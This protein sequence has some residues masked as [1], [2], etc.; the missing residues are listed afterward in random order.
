[1]S[2]GRRLDRLTR[3]VACA[4]PLLFLA[5]AT[6]QGWL[7]PGYDPIAQPISALALGPRGWVQEVNFG[8]LAGALATFA[9]VLRRDL[10]GG[11]GA[12]VGPAV[13]LL[14]AI[15][16]ALAGVFP[17]DEPGAPATATGRL[18]VLGG[19]LVFP[20]MPVVLLHVGRRFRRDR[21]WRPYHASTVI[22]GLLSAAT[23]AFFLLFV[24]VP[25]ASAPR[26][27]THLAGL[28]QRIQLFPFLLWVALV[29]LRARPA[30]EEGVVPAR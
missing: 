8:V 21:R 7:R 18:H 13:I 30:A 4:G 16:V 3:W 12:V 9:L 28:V 1:M 22:L 5:V 6:A 11:V 17:M 2:H 29:A 24:G 19:F 25:G 26:L 27:A 15:G 23:I 20:W 10:R 14:M